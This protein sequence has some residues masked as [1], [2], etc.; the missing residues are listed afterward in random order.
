MED[1]VTRPEYEEHNKRMDDE[2]KR[3]NHR[4]GDVE[5]GVDQFN[6]LL[7]SVD[8]LALSMEN[9]QKEQMAQREDIEELKSRDGKMWRKAV[10]YVISAAVGLVV[11]FAFKQIGI[12]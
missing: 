7:A 1:F 9:M 5:K 2:H 4:L 10:G 3:M 8:R 6:K 11:G 12:V